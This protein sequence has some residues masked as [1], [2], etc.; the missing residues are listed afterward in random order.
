[1]PTIFRKRPLAV[2]AVQWTGENFAELQAFAGENVRYSDGEI[3]AGQ[4]GWERGLL[5]RTMANGWVP[6]PVGEWVIKGVAGEFYPCADSVLR[7]SY[8][9]V[10]DRREAFLVAYLRHNPRTG[11]M[12]V[13]HVAIK[14][15]GAD[16]LTGEQG[17]TY[18]DLLQCEG[19]DFQEAIDQVIAMVRT[20]PHLH[21]TLPWIDDK[22]GYQNSAEREA[23]LRSVNDSF[24]PTHLSAEAKAAV[25]EAMLSVVEDQVRVNRVADSLSAA[26]AT[27]LWAAW[28]TAVKEP[29]PRAQHRLRLEGESAW[30]E[31]IGGD[32]YRSL[33]DCFDS[34]LV[35]LDSRLPLQEQPAGSQL[36][37]EQGPSLSTFEGRKARLLWG[38]LF[39][40]K[41]TQSGI[42]PFAI[43]GR[44][45]SPVRE[46]P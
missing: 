20:Y 26:F 11:G 31:H 45:L 19:S 9:Q 8:V 21:W 27:G 40:G 43:V 2:E 18:A 32:L 10:E 6:S 16:S 17:T 42:I 13:A 25:N 14:S 39:S 28:E 41:Q 46:R 7:A 30:C 35:R 23:F 34:V 33:N 22:E 36:Q 4:M 15:E 3:P 38:C 5:I 12:A 29:K 44:D 24:S 37:Q 1:M